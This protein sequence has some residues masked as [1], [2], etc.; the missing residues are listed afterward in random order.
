METITELE[1]ELQTIRLELDSFAGKLSY[2]ASEELQ[3]KTKIDFKRVKEHAQKMPLK[4]HILTRKSQEAS[5]SY[6]YLLGSVAATASEDSEGCL[7]LLQQVI[8]SCKINDLDLETILVKGHQ[9]DRFDL[10]TLVEQLLKNKLSDALILDSLLMYY[11]YESGNDHM[12][13]YIN[14]LASI[15]IKDIKRLRLIVHVAQIIVKQDKRALAR[16]NNSSNMVLTK[17]T[18][19][20]WTENLTNVISGS[21][22]WGR[23]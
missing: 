14:Q 1:K 6:L 13:E 11:T 3:K 23:C 4:G 16:F 17:Q 15:L 9:L 8:D 10:R 18:Y 12:L 7:I 19:R 20:C 2:Y 21:F 22:Y 5:S